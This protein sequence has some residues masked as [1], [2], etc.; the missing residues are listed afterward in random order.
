MLEVSWHT[1][2]KTSRYSLLLNVCRYLLIANM[3]SSGEIDPF[4]APEA[5]PYAAH[6]DRHCGFDSDVA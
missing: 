4:E 6:V 3:L 1:G 5:K 2:P